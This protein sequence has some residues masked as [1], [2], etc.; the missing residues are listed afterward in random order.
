[1]IAPVI[2]VPERRNTFAL[3]TDPCISL[4]SRLHLVDYLTVHRTDSGLSAKNSLR[5][6]NRRGRIDIHILS[7]EYRMRRYNNLHQQIASRPAV[8]ARFTLVADPDTLAIINTRRNINLNPLSG[9]NITG[10]PAVRT[11]LTDNLS[12]TP[13][14]RTFPNILNHAKQ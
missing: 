11:L 6:G 12:G 3:Q 10:T 2:L 1:M 9:G 4:R 13:A 14:V 7:L 5:I 8:H